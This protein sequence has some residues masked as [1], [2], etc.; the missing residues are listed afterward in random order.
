MPSDH[1][2]Y[3]ARVEQER[4]AALASK[5][6]GARRAHLELAFKYAQLAGIGIDENVPITQQAQSDPS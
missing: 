1:S 6:P 4:R 5:N 3:A 2:Y